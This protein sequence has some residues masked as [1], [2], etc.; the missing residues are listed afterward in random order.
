MNHR[1]REVGPLAADSVAHEH[2]GCLADRMPGQK[3]T[4]QMRTT[5]TCAASSMAPTCVII[6]EDDEAP[7]IEGVPDTD[8][9]THLESGAQRVGSRL[10]GACRR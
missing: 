1:A 5:M 10:V 9:Y 2:T 3:L 6:E 4:E 8:G 7:H